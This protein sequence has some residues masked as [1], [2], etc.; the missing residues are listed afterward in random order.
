M[1]QPELSEM[2]WITAGWLLGFAGFNTVLGVAWWRRTREE[3]QFLRVARRSVVDPIQAGWW[4]GASWKGASAQ[5]EGYAAEVAVRLLVLAGHAQ[6]DETGRISLTPGQH[7]APE[8]PALAALAAALRRDEGV[9]VHELLTEPR[10][11]P[12]RTA[13]EA[14][15][16][17]LRRCF[18]AYRVPALLAALVVS[19][20]M[21]MNAMLLGNGFPGLSDQDPGWWTLLWMA[22]WAALSLLAAAWPPEAS[23]PW[24]RFTRRCRA[25]LA[26]ALAGESPETG[27]SV[28]RG[29]YPPPTSQAST[30]G[31]NVRRPPDGSTDRTGRGNSA[32][33]ANDTADLDMDHDSGFVGGD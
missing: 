18:G 3:R 26:R 6:V 1:S 13:L 31:A 8:D 25:A 19:F 32:E 30:A 28:S 9:T 10:F 5:R 23:R 11:A 15:R 20:G 12:F 14:H 7:G 22:P 2:G 4:L 27:F 24:P 29:A 21:S 33:L 16:A 17:P